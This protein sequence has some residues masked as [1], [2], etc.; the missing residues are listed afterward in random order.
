MGAPLTRFAWLSIAAAVV[1]IGL[2]AAA[3]ALTGSVGLLSDALEGLVNLVAAGI[4]LAALTVAAKPADDEHAYGHHKA[5]YF[6]SGTEGALIVIAAIAI[7]IAAVDRL[8]SPR[9]L[10][11]LGVGLVVS[12]VA[13]LVNF[14]VARVM[15]RV[16]RRERSIALEADGRHLMTDVY[17]SIGVVAGVGA[18]AVSG[19]VWLDP[20]V[21]IAV[22][23][24]ILGNGVALIRR[25]MLGL[26]DASI[27]REDREKVVA[28]LESYAEQGVRWHA[29]RTRQAGVRNFVS[30]HV[31]VPGAWSVKRA[32]DV[33]EE[34]ERAIR[35][36]LGT[37]TVETHL[38]PVE[39]EASYRDI[40]LDRTT[41]P[42]E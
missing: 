41:V 38:E 11:R 24:W 40:G 9:P 29:L 15:L 22:G 39:D 35:R 14:V 23:I 20:L 28:I 37:A 10:E 26:L 7:I 5:E 12:L 16:G 2:K 32:H 27:P 25:S 4:A 8:L 36:A 30:V 1:T 19:L 13:A 18:V 3:W 6:S 33:A 31:L 34:I 42:R 21:A 17:T